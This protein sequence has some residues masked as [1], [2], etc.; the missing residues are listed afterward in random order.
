MN[1][2]KK[3]GLIISGIG[4]SSQQTICRT[5][6]EYAVKKGFQVEIFVVYG[7]FGTNILTAEGEANIVNLPDF[8]TF[9]GIITL[10]DVLDIPHFL[11]KLESQLALAHCPVVCIRGNG[12]RFHDV[13]LENQK[14]IERLMQH[15]LGEGK[16]RICFL[17]GREALKDSEW[18]MDGYL[19]AME[20]YG[21]EVQDHMVYHGNYWY[22]C[23]VD[24]VDRFYSVAG[25][26]PEVIVCANDFMAIGVIE[27]LKK[28]GKKI[29]EEVQVSGFDDIDE[30]MTV[31]PTL[32]TLRVP[33]EEMARAAVDMIVE[34]LWG[35][36]VEQARYIS[37]RPVYRGSTGN[38]DE[39]D[40]NQFITNTSKRMKRLE[41]INQQNYYFSLEFEETIDEDA[42]YRVFARY[43]DNV[44]H[45]RK[46]YVCLCDESEREYEEVDMYSKYTEHMIL[47]CAI[48]PHGS[49]EMMSERFERRMILPE[50]LLE[51]SD[52]RVIV[53]LHFKNHC[54]GYLVIDYAEYDIFDEFVQH[55]LLRLGEMLENLDLEHKVAAANEM[56]VAATYD[57]LTG[58]RNR[59]GFEQMGRFYL[60]RALK[61]GCSLMIMTIDMDNLKT[62]NDTYGHQEGDRALIGLAR[63]L[64]HAIADRGDIFCSRNGGDEFVVCGLN[65]TDD[66]V[67]QVIADFRETLILS[68]ETEKLPYIPGASVGY[69]LGI[70][71][72]R[73]DMIEYLHISDE[74]MYEDKKQRKAHR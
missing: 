56:R 9:D 54:F 74:K 23:A 65:M 28:R 72:H 15:F 64:E 37:C 60:E 52:Y 42:I 55:C 18:R 47:K 27:E 31:Y 53:Q 58:I 21:I 62:I 71:K 11:E 32:T 29:P 1:T 50:H 43:A 44:E 22:S 16:T 59:R 4:Y 14:S 34:E 51:E 5:V 8:S 3:I 63:A 10:L 25:W 33:F 13:V 45:F 36:G 68:G 12:S 38:T 17:S 24:A 48:A 73:N 6:A 61:E 69:C 70:P 39:M 57:E 20:R 41:T 46:I 7:S 26:E 30:C 19:H 35:R 67:A 49:Y 40:M 2:K 66:E